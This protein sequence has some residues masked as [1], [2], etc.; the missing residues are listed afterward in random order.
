MVRAFGAM[1]PVQ[2]LRE[3]S[4]S[5]RISHGNVTESLL[6]PHASPTWCIVYCLV[7][8]ARSARRCRVTSSRCPGAAAAA[9][10]VEVQTAG[11]EALVCLT[12]C[13]SLA[14]RS[15]ARAACARLHG[16]PSS[17][18]TSSAAPVRR[19][20]RRGHHSVCPATHAWSCR[21]ATVGLDAETVHSG[22][23]P[24][25]GQPLIS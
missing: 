4:R 22:R 25:G 18:P 14:G 13:R 5:F 17:H 15:S 2:S 20:E 8:V 9:S 21:P 12:V 16:T 23:G 10:A 19:Y 7:A 3:L 6:M 11:T 1:G 24:N